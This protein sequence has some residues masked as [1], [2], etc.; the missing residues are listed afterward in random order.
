MLKLILMAVAAFLMVLIAVLATAMP[1]RLIL[2]EAVGVETATP[3]QVY[4]RLD[5]DD[6]LIA[7]P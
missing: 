5:R 7:K 6:D 4:F 3:Q 2:H 1:L